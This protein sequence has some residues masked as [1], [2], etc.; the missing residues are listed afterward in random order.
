VERALAE[1]GP[2]TPH[3]EVLREFG[4]RRFQRTVRAKVNFAGLGAL[5]PGVVVDL[6]H[7]ASRGF[8]RIVLKSGAILVSEIETNHSLNSVEV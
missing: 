8:P 6:T 1:P 7:L 4:L 3:E 5:R 2:S